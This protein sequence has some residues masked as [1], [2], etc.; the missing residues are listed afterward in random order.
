M[1]CW[2][3]E[4]PKAEVSLEFV[5]ILEALISLSSLFLWLRLFLLYYCLKSSS[6]LR[7]IDSSILLWF[8][9]MF[10]FISL[11]TFCLN[12]LLPCP[13]VLGTPV[14][15]EPRVALFDLQTRCKSILSLLTILFFD[16]FEFLVLDAEFELFPLLS[17]TGCAVEKFWEVLLLLPLN[18]VSLWLR[19]WTR[20]LSLP[21]HYEMLCLW[22]ICWLVMWDSLALGEGSYL[23]VLSLEGLRWR[24][25]CFELRK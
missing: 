21:A 3:V 22:L 15:V 19:S 25:S 16:G 24:R 5:T 7:I 4:G 10:Y 12:I 11:S 1:G 13:K 8:L 20:V 17:P 9:R 18:V 23:P 2:R 14:V 6:Y